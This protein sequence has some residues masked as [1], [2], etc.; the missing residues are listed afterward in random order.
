MSARLLPRPLFS[1]TSDCLA[2][3]YLSRAVL[4]KLTRLKTDSGFTLLQA[5]ASGIKNPDSSIGLYAGDAQSYDLFASLFDPIIHDYH[6][7]SK[8]SNS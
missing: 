4:E 6:S 8:K 1:E 3:K 5:L 7:F 2:K